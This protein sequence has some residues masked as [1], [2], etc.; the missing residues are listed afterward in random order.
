MSNVIMRVY[1]D[2]DGE[3][4]PLDLCADCAS[5]YAEEE[6]AGSSI[7]AVVWDYLIDKNITPICEECGCK[8][9]SRKE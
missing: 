5:A 7:N 2:E 6:H 8:L 1:I 9:S 4:T 3:Q